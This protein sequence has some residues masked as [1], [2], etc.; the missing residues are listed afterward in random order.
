M[1][2]M[3]LTT[4]TGIIGMLSCKTP[5]LALKENEWQSTEKIEVKGRQ[6]WTINEKL[7]F[8]NYQTVTLKRS[9]TKG[10][11]AFAGWTAYKPGFTEVEKKIGVEYSQRKQSVRFELSDSKNQESAAFCVA[12]I[13]SGNFVINKNPNSAVGE[14]NSILEIGDDWQ[15]GYWVE[16][17]LKHEDRP[18]EMVIDHRNVERQRKNYTGYLALDRNNYYTIKPV[19][20]LRNSNGKTVN[21]I[22]NSIGFEFRNKAGKPVAAVSLMDQG[23]VYFEKLSDQEKFLLANACTALLLEQQI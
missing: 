16:I 17:Y 13:K 19:Y 5:D 7:S 10:S 21:T 2:R 15:N 18:W 3:I 11:G 14:V 8:G 4:L 12:K 6:G 20:A 22:G 9:W 23:I 1:N